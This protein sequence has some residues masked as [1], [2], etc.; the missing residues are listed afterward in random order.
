MLLYKVG[1]TAVLLY[2]VGSTAVL[3]TVLVCLRIIIM[4]M[5]NNLCQSGLP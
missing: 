5:F 4:Y 2:K 3:L 1:S